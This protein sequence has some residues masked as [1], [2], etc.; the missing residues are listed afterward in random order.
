MSASIVAYWPGMTKEQV[1]SERG[2]AATKRKQAARLN[3]V[4]PRRNGALVV[5]TTYPRSSARSS[6]AAIAYQVQRAAGVVP[7]SRARRRM[8]RRWAPRKAGQR[9]SAGRGTAAFRRGR[10]RA[11]AAGR[12]GGA[13]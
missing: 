9:R 7:A 6:A 5:Q 1:E 8:R 4:G 11:Q 13:A 12:R 10:A 2:R 3:L